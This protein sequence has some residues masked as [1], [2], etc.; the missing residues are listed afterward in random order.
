MATAQ[1]RGDYAHAGPQQ[2]QGGGEGEVRVEGV[3][4][5][6]RCCFYWLSEH[7]ERSMSAAER[8]A[9]MEASGKG[10]C[11]DE[12]LAQQGFA[13]IPG[14]V[15]AGAGTLGLF[16]ISWGVPGRGTGRP[17]LRGRPRQRLRRCAL[18]VPAL[19]QLGFWDDSQDGTV[20]AQ[21]ASLCN[22]TAVSAGGGCC[23]SGQTWR[24]V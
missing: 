3:E 22:A 6:L 7:A 13:G 15:F 14:S 4:I 19:G 23:A 18:R 17:G 24:K 9:W 10:E 12:A 8:V 20:A 11:Q 21:A 16:R 1:K 2:Q 5:G